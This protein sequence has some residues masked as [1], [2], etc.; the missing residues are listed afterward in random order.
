[1]YL[2]LFKISECNGILAEFE[3]K[4]FHSKCAHGKLL[5]IGVHRHSLCMRVFDF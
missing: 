2:E 5:G 4:C 3:I 1:M